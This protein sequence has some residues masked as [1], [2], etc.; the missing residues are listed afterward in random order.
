MLRHMEISSD[1]SGSLRSSEP[2][3]K[4]YKQALCKANSAA[5]LVMC[6]SA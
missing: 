3:H 5:V 6:A 1:C 4:M 2:H